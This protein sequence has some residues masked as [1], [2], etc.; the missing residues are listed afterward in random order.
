VHF[1]LLVDD[2]HNAT[3]AVEKAGARQLTH[4]LDPGPKAWQIYADP[5]RHPICLVS[6]PE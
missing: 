4:L 5:A 1:D 6:V 2:L 3:L